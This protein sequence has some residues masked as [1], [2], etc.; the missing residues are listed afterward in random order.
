MKP[1]V[2]IHFCRSHLKCW[3][4]CVLLCS[5]WNGFAHAAGPDDF[6]FFEKKIRPILTDNCFKCHSHSSEKLKGGL[7]L[8]S[9]D[10]LL[11]GGEGGLVV[12][13]AKPLESRLLEAIQYENADLQMPPKRMLAPEQISAVREWIKMGVPWP[14]EKLAETKPASSVFDLEKRRREHWAWQPIRHVSPPGVSNRKWPTSA[15]DRFLLARLEQKHLRPAAIAEPRTLIRRLYFDLVGLPPA[16][17]K[18]EQ[19]ANAHSPADY[20]RVVDELLASPHFGERW[21]R[22]WLDLVRYS[23]TLGHEFDYA[24]PNAWRYRDYV[25][26]AFNDDVPYRQFVMEHIA[27]DLLRNPRRHLAEHFNESVIGTAF[28]WLGQREH[29]PVDVRLHQAEVTDNQIDVLSKTFLGLTVAC[30]RCHDHKFDAIS[31]KDYYSLYGV[32]ES[33]RYA[34]VSI[35][36]PEAANKLAERLKVLKRKLAVSIAPDWSKQSGSIAKYLLATAQA[37]PGDNKGTLDPKLLERW[38]AALAQ[39]DYSRPDHPL[40]A[41]TQL[42]RSAA[43]NT[44]PFN[45][46]CQ[47]LIRCNEKS[48]SSEPSCWSFSRAWFRQAVRGLVL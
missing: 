19:F 23:E 32:L 1:V 36:D 7:L 26:R 12:N 20:A 46:L 2:V 13:L 35:D 29:S 40:Y 45:Q 16:P 10:G 4:G 24:I 18:V 37:I 8:D 25:I 33:C 3:L 34:Q 27:G 48:A 5:I 39:K 30:A 41:W 28:L 6:E 43:T 31:T 44:L 47:K 38:S 9:R 21:A 17:G 42:S 15:P 11:K 14:T 22:H